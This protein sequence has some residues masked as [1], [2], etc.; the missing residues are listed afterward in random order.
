MSRLTRMSS[1]VFG[2]S[3]KEGAILQKSGGRRKHV[4][5]DENAS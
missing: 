5:M 1:I 3:K 4:E 2:A